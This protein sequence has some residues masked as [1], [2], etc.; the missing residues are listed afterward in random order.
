MNKEEIKKGIA[1]YGYEQKR[2]LRLI[3]KTGGL[4]ASK[5]DELFRENE[6]KQIRRLCHRG[7]TGDTFL[8]GIGVN[9][10]N[11]WAE[12]LDLMQ[13]MMAIDLID[14]KRNEDNEIVYILN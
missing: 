11:L 7:I 4:S 6:Y 3:R 13:H 5:F 8:L 2:L 14:T 9:G 10:F 1:G 12:T